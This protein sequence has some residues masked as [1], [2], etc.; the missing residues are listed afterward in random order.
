MTNSPKAALA[1]WTPFVVCMSIFLGAFC[2]AA[3]AAEDDVAAKEAARAE[4]VTDAE[5]EAAYG[6]D[7]YGNR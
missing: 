5:C 3:A 4:C 6:F 1:M 2:W 7:M